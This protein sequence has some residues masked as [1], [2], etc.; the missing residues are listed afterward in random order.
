[1]RAR[2]ERDSLKRIIHWDKVEE[3]FSQYH[4][5][6][7]NKRYVF[8][9][10]LPNNAMPIY[11]ELYYQGQVYVSQAYN[12]LKGKK[13]NNIDYAKNIKKYIDTIKQIA[14]QERENELNF[15]INW[16]KILQSDKKGQIT[17][18][19][20]DFAKKLNSRKLDDPIDYFDLMA[21]FKAIMEIDNNFNRKRDE[22]AKHNIEVIT[23][24]FK[25]LPI[26][27]QKE[28]ME[29][30]HS[31]TSKFHRL[32]NKYLLGPVKIKD[33]VKQYETTLMNVYAE[34]FNS[35][36]V[37]IRNDQT[38]LS[39]ILDNF[40]D[41]KTWNEKQ[42]QAMILGTIAQYL[43]DLDPQKLIDEK[44]KQ[45]A[46]DITNNFE[47]LSKK[48]T[49]ARAEQIIKAV[50]EKTFVSIEE[51]ALTTHRQ[52][53]QD[54]LQLTTEERNALLNKF[55]L[56]NDTF[57]KNFYNAKEEDIT[58]FI[59]NNGGQR[60]VK[61]LISKRL[62]KVI[63]DYAEKN[64]SDIFKQF[65]DPKQIVAAIK[66]QQNSQE[67]KFFNTRKM[68]SDHF[69][70]KVYGHSLA[71]HNLEQNITAM[72]Q[73]KT[74]YLGKF[75]HDK[76]DAGITVSYKPLNLKE[77]NYPNLT[78]KIKD[79]I[80]NWGINFLTLYNKLS[81]NQIDVSAAA[82]AYE[83]RIRSINKAMNTLI[84]RLKDKDTARNKIL[85]AL[86]QYVSVAIQVKEYSYSADQ[87]TF[88]SGSLGANIEKQ[89]N[90]IQKMYELGGITMQDYETLY[91]VAINCGED[92]MAHSLKQHL[93]HYLLAGAALI[94]FDEGFA[95]AES[96]ME[97]MRSL[98]NWDEKVV[99]LYQIQNTFVPASLVLSNIYNNLI[100]VYQDIV[101][102][103]QQI[104]NIPFTQN[105]ITIDN[106][107]T[108][109]RY[110]P[111]WGDYNTSPYNKAQNRWDKVS[112]EASNG[113]YKLGDSNVL[114][115]NI[116]FSFLGG[117]LDILEKIPKT[118]SNPI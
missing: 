20:K 40:K 64:F 33:Q 47:Q 86:R 94:T 57:F 75:G 81:N 2:K 82:E 58:N 110:K 74:V 113:T 9:K 59:N 34:K 32:V 115:I 114:N 24:N 29:A 48:M 36:L 83:L 65:K 14:M 99:H 19:F 96:F 92:G 26:E 66:Q 61:Q 89:L 87:F 15:I 23:N 41:K 60:N 105:E 85:E 80:E 30:Q 21:A 5:I 28:I 7:A 8:F 78:K 79:Q 103:L 84:R 46:N 3:N 43:S 95:N 109:E 70:V 62:G 4:E 25:N 68:I 6:S 90:N 10:S 112:Q 71:E 117:L 22:L 55:D 13:T 39:T 98:Y 35:V 11:D 76:T 18:D 54:F 108:E 102:E 56:R 42:I 49:L 106:T 118:F 27:I 73:G 100:V 63:R 67:I 93:E 104:S 44:G 31:D 107:I 52:I 53:G 16:E 88:D 97:K 37:N 51:K 12:I 111:L 91:F 50:S 101:G 72:I 45:L 69:K 17:E 38:L 116:R 1:M 77:F